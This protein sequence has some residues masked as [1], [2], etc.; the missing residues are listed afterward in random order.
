MARELPVVEGRRGPSGGVFLLLL[1]FVLLFGARSIASFIIDYHWWSEIGQLPTWQNIIL[2]SFVPPV[3]AALLVFAVLWTVH[4]RALNYAGAALRAHR[5]YS[6]I[7]TLVLLLLSWVIAKAAMNSWTIVSFYGAQRAGASPDGG[8][9]DPIFG[10]TLAFYLFELPFYR[11]LLGLLLATGIVAVI[12]FYVPARLWQMSSEFERMRSG[13]EISVSF[14]LPGDLESWMLRGLLAFVLTIMAIRAYLGRYSFLQEEHRFL[15]G[16]DYLNHNIGI[17]LQWVLVAALL[18]AAVLVLMR[19][20]RWLVLP[21]AL[22]VIRAI[23]PAVVSAVYVK[24]NEIT[25][26]TP[27]ITHHL[28]ATRTAYG[29]DG[30]LKESV[31]PATLEAPISYTAHQP[32]FDNVRLWDWR[33]FHD[34]VT[35]LQALRQYYV[36]ADTDVDRYMLG[37]RLRQVM[38]TPR[39]LDIRQLP[40]ARANWI[41]GHFIYTHGYGL[42]MAEANRVT[43]NG[44][45]DLVVQD[46]PPKINVQGL[47]ITRPE[48]YFG[49]VTH[50]PVYVRTGQPEFNYPSGEGNVQTKYEGKGG[51]PVSGFGMKLAA[52]IAEGDHKL[53]LTEYV[54]PETRMLIRRNVRERVSTLASF[55]DW[56]ADPY[57]VVTDAGRLVWML[58]GYTTSNS[59]PYSQRMNIRGV[60]QVNYIRNSVKATVDAY[61][62]DVRMYVFDERDPV[63]RAFRGIFP[64]LFTPADQ[65]PADLRSHT[66]YPELLFQA[67]A[68]I[69]RAYHMRDPQAFYNREDLWDI[70]KNVYGQAGQ[71]EALAPLYTVASLPGEK[72]AEYLLIQPFTP[73]S[74]DNLIGV[75]IARNDGEHLG[76]IVVLQLSKQSL[77]YGPLQ[78][79]ARVDSDSTI[80]KDLTLWNQQGS[81]VLRGQMLV[82]PVAGTFVYVE[83]IYIQSAQARMP[84]MKK[85]VLA[86]GNR[87]IYRDTWEE[88]LSELTG[89]ATP[90]G[91]GAATQTSNTAPPE[92]QPVAAQQQQQPSPV[93]PAGP[94]VEQIRTHMRRYRELSSQGRWSEAGRELEAVERLVNGG[95]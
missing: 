6:R 11:E 59:H 86:M 68:E 9:R 94:A 65:M 7:A 36:F 22:V 67:Q 5:S 74:K 70:A 48:L 32:T 77:I 44:Q 66:R 75:M 76:E 53:L 84:Q 46:A 89:T 8:W 81:Q 31:Y 10:N 42:V 63:I 72:Q 1:F 38:L 78:I 30:R 49:E 87:L 40:D 41:N 57:L 33:A 15:V 80:S 61:E 60:G 39:E 3:A 43:S 73:R 25:L 14:F 62:G 28:N 13:R 29:L 55:I 20:I 56:D 2:Y 24:P 19:K 83:P 54:T 79:E 92:P 91:G 82:L 12:V 51:I 50:E 95:R 45:P 47:Q 18:L 93:Q 64:E 71:T 16:V 26:Q 4:A 34:T 58:D 52:A 27:Y 17:P 88:V 35:Q 21:V 69:Y 90:S 23:V 85:V 37:G